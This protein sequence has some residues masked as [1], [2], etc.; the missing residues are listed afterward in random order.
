MAQRL[1]ATAGYSVSEDLTR[2]AVSIS[3]FSQECKD[4]GEIQPNIEDDLET[5]IRDAYAGREAD[6][7]NLP[8]EL[9]QE[10]E[11][12]VR[13]LMKLG[14]DVNTTPRICL[15]NWPKSWKPQCVSL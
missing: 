11:A 4:Q 15:L 14:R 6:P 2:D 12:A 7:K 10:L 8:V 9:A 5:R 3:E 1:L 13:Q